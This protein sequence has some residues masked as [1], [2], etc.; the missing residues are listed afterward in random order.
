VVL[1]G[2]AKEAEGF[3]MTATAK[4]IMPWFGGDAGSAREIIAQFG[5]HKAYIEPFCGGMSVLF[6]K[7]RVVNERVNDL[8]GALINLAQVLASEE[9]WEIGRAHV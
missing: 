8:N 4:Q 5:E 9:H 6:A 7:P 1:L 3:V 2:R